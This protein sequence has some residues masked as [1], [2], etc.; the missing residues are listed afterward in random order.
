[1]QTYPAFANLTGNFK[2]AKNVLT[3]AA[4]D[5]TDEIPDLSSAGPVYDGRLAPQ[6]TAPGPN[7]TSDAAAFV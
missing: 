1:M 5:S 2:M 4:I 6:L 7:G 3:I